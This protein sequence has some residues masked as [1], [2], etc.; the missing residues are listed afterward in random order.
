MLMLQSPQGEKKQTGTL[1]PRILAVF[2]CCPLS[3]LPPC[4]HDGIGT[5]LSVFRAES[6]FPY[7][8]C[9][10]SLICSHLIRSGPCTTGLPMSSLLPRPLPPA[11]IQ[12]H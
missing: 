6:P 3:P 8:G 5:L 2:S 12:P 1:L 4:P 7:F 11:R 9:D 10:I